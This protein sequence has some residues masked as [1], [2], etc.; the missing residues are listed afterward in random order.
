MPLIAKNSLSRWD[1]LGPSVHELRQRGF[2]VLTGGTGLHSSS[3]AQT[4]RR[5]KLR[6]QA[7]TGASLAASPHDRHHVRKPPGMPWSRHDLASYCTCLVRGD[8][9]ASSYGPLI[10]CAKE[11]VYL[12]ALLFHVSAG[13]RATAL[14]DTTTGSPAHRCA[15]FAGD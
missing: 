12:I 2:V 4:E 9:L 15:H 6:A 13:V 8:Q 5:T 7:R 14:E 10:K 1:W 11:A 3:R